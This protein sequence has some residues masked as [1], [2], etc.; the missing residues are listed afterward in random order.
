MDSQSASERL[1]TTKLASKVSRYE[2]IRRNQNSLNL[3]NLFI[4][5]IGSIIF[6]PVCHFASLD[7]KGQ[8]HEDVLLPCAVIYK[9]E[10]DYNL[11]VVHWQ[12]LENDV[13]VHTFYYGSSQPEY[14]SV[15]YRGRTEMFYDLLPSGNLSLLL[16]NLSES[17]AGIY[18]CHSVLQ[19]TSGITIQYVNLRIEGRNEDQ[20]QTP[21]D[22]FPRPIFMRFIIIIITILVFILAFSVLYFPSKL[23]RIGK[24]DEENK[25][26]IDAKPQESVIQLYKKHMTSIIQHEAYSL[27]QRQ[28][29]VKKCSFLESFGKMKTYTEDMSE[30]INADELFTPEKQQLISRRMFLLGDAGSGKSYFCKWLRT[31]W[32]QEKITMYRCILYLSSKKL[33]NNLSL[34]AVCDEIYSNLSSVLSM[35]NIL[36]IFDGIDD[37]VCENRNSDSTHGSEINCSLSVYT[38]LEKIMK[39]LLVPDVDVLIVC[40]N[41]S[42]I[43]LQKECNSAFILLD[44]TEQETE[45]VYNTITAKDQK[46]DKRRETI[47][48]ITHMPAFVVMMSHFSNN[49]HLEIIRDS[50]PY[51][52]LTD[53]LLKWTTKVIG[54]RIKQNIFIN[55]ASQ[56]YENLIKGKPNSTETMESWDKFLILYNCEVQ[57]KYQCNLLRDILAA[58]HCVWEIHRTG[59]LK[60]C[61]DFWVFGS[62]I[63]RNTVLLKS[64][65]DQHNAKYYHF[66][67]FFMRLLAYPDCE[68]LYNNTPMKNSRM[69]DLLSDWFKENICRCRP[70]EKLKLIH[71]IFELHDEIVTEEVLS[72][73]K[74]LEL[75]NTPLNFRDIQALDY[76]FKGIELEELDLRLCA[77]EDKS[78]KRLRSV[79]KNTKIVML[80][81]NHLTK[82]TG[83][84]LGEIL[85]EPGCIIEKLSLGTNQLGNHG[86]QELWKAVKHNK[87]LTGLYVYDNK[88]TDEGTHGM[89]E[90]LQENLSLQELHLCGNTF[91]D[92]GLTNI[93]KLKDTKKELNVVLR[94]AENLELFEYV[95]NKI[96][97]LNQTWKSYD[98]EYLDKLLVAVLKDLEKRDCNKDRQISWERVDNLVQEIKK[99][100]KEEKRK[101]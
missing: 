45:N 57:C 93:L 53:T 73:L 4:K 75:F 70:S 5:F 47:Y 84:L 100:Q 64:V 92:D 59:G 94:I 18:T 82:E 66:I 55:M 24:N 35:D 79:I 7:V 67:R 30:T 19:E 86:A 52:I 6:L 56:S 27:S 101:H 80:S 21:G 54:E 28:L 37:L 51:K 1:A 63:H 88:I 61:L 36:L 76:C 65:E 48:Y 78:V 85:G 26:L 13:V 41:D 90:H 20:I 95:E 14:Q 31:K 11:L 34:E 81:S 98:Q 38:L 91:G 60:E 68:S 77:L 17:D 97:S 23:N 42:L 33:K 15:Q 74:K 46:S 49:H 9:D 50:S 43:D 12:R 40:R 3:K 2:T 69:Q 99:V 22:V 8:L 10:F 25:A 71:C 87:T 16:R 62:S 96:R 89:V 58:A 44:F 32:I 39:K 83:K 72:N 29:L